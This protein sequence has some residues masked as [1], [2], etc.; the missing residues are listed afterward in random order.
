M[1]Y[2]KM[3]FW[4]FLPIF[5]VGFSFSFV[6]WF[7]DPLK[8]FH[9]PFICENTIYDSARYS[10]RGLIDTMD[11]DS[12]I[13]GTS[14]LENTSA[15]EASDK[16]GGRFINISIG[17]SY[18][19]ERKIVLNYLM[20]RKKI[21]N[22]LYSLDTFT[23]VGPEKGGDKNFKIEN[24]DYLYNDN[25]FDDF[26]AYLNSKYISYI[27]STFFTFGKKCKIADFDRPFAWYMY[28]DHKKRFGG[29]QI[30]AKYSDN[31]QLK[32]HIEKIKN[33]ANGKIEKIKNL[34]FKENLDNN[35]LYFAKNY[36]QTKFILFIPPY[37]RLQ[38]AM[39]VRQSE[40][41]VARK[42]AIKYLLDQNLSN[43]KIYAFDDMDFT[44]DI[45]N[46]KD[47]GHYSEAINLKMSDWIAN[48][49]GLLTKD[50]FE[51]WWQN[52]EKLA[53]EFDLEGFNNELQRL[54]K[55][56]K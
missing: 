48:D 32:Y 9:K 27:F 51:S 14:M 5:I 50:N 53:K 54:I 10:V 23:L 6:L 35:I 2:K 17:G 4:Y 29:I 24:F 12:V 46:Y 42:N 25:L 7:V 33:A 38:S 39:Y 1:N 18:F 26:R 36:P 47:L 40:L 21:K 45:A 8:L 15:K 44:A 11:F 41:F 19:Y 52:Y 3:I 22:I 43:I 37:S 13:L 16:L 20:K 28:E 34:S 49:I 55:E 56:N 30:W 31:E